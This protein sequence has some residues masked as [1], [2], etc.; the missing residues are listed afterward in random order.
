MTI[1]KEI[2][3]EEYLTVSETKAILRDLEVERATQDR[4]MHYVLS[5]SIGHANR[6]AELDP[7]ESRELVDRLQ[8]LEKVDEKT[9]YKIADLL[10][11]DRNELRAIYAQER[12]ALSGE[13]LDEI[14]GVLARYVE[15][16]DAVSP[17]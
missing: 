2:V 6:F 9:A 11:R 14:L 1:F 15:V 7:D 12:Y 3:E 4:E 8:E 17:G 13:E 10:P 5:R 16:T